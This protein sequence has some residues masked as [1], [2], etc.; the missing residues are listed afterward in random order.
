M[1]VTRVYRIFFVGVLGFSTGLMWFQSQKPYRL[2]YNP[3]LGSTPTL[4]S[5]F[6]LNLKP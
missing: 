6:K 4:G 3:A 1:G 5:P 2:L